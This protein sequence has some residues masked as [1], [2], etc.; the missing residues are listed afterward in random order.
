MLTCNV[1]DGQYPGT[2]KVAIRVVLKQIAKA[3]DLELAFQQHG[4]LGPDTFEV[5]YR[6]VELR[7]VLLND[8]VGFGPSKMAN[9]RLWANNHFCV[10]FVSRCKRRFSAA[11]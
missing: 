1:A 4:T 2:V 3:S 8:C 10:L 9:P 7:N 6:G 5:F 11:L